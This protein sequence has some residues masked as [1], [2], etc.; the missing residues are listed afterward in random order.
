MLDA[1]VV[2]RDVAALSAVFTGCRE[3]LLAILSLAGPEI[4]AFR[5]LAFSGSG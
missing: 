2:Y 3:R 1:T 5:V 4:R